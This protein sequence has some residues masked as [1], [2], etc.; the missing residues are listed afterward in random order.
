M[1]KKKENGSNVLKEKQLF[2][3]NNC[4]KVYKNQKSFLKHI[5]KIVQKKEIRECNNC[6][7]VYR[8][9]KSFINHVCKIK[10]CPEEFKCEF[11]NKIFK[12]EKVF[13]KHI[14]EKKKRFDDKN[15]K[16]FNLA[17]QFYNSMYAKKR[18]PKTID[19]FI[20]SR[21]YNAFI[22]FS[23]YV[24]DINV[25]NPSFFV[26]F[27]LDNNIKID[28][29]TLPNVYDLYI[30]EL[31][32]LETASAALER[33]FKLMEQWEI[34]TSNKWTDFFRK[35]DTTLAV[36]WIRS[37]RISPWVL[38]T[39]SSSNELL[40]RMTSEQIKLIQNSLDPIFW[41]EKLK[42]EQD[43]VIYIQKILEEVGL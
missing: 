40:S 39:A 4:G 26:K 28:D 15:Q 25:I 16:Y 32:K 29:W 8:I 34:E 19:D 33:N 3:C 11:C 31:T 22:K 36:L 30:R 24:I 1:K 38:Y 20:N 37:G 42:K 27:L 41:E 17:F 2:E 21:L 9:K 23:K 18:K 5:C 10:K 7:K 43:E 6:G 12:Y 13:I 35:I 14:C